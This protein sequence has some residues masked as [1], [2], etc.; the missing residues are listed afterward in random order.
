MISSGRKGT[1]SV[2]ICVGDPIKFANNACLKLINT[3]NERIMTYFNFKILSD[4][5]NLYPV[6]SH[7]G[8]EDVKRDAFAI[9][10]RTTQEWEIENTFDDEWCSCCGGETSMKWI[11]VSRLSPPTT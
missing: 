1:N 9:W 8:S 6:C 10:N 4:D 11:E 5:P 7:C 3:P 2:F